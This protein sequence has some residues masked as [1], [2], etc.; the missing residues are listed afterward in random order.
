MINSR[1][2]QLKSTHAANEQELK[3]LSATKTQLQNQVRH[4]GER[5]SKRSKKQE[6]D[7]IQN[8]TK[9]R[10]VLLS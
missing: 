6:E 8:Q 4:V 9:I 7:F 2:D 3:T 5:V 1:I 10:Y